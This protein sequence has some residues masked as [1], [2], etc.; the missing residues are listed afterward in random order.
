M[1]PPE[2][3]EESAELAR[4]LG[5]EPVCGSPLIPVLNDTPAFDLFLNRLF[6]GEVKT[7]I[8]TSATG[9]GAALQ[10]AGRRKRKEEL[11][12]NLRELDII[13]IGPRTGMSL[14][15]YGI[16]FR[17]PPAFTS[18]GI[19]ELISRSSPAK[20]IFVLRSDSGSGTLESGIRALGFELH[21]VIVYSLVKELKGLDP[22]IEFTLKNDIDAFAFT[23]SLSATAFLEALVAG[24]W[25][26]S[27]IMS[28]PVIGAIGPPTRSTL[29]SW[30]L[31][32]DV[33]PRR[34]TFYD[35]LI[36]VRNAYVE[37][38]C[39]DGNGIDG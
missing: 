25:N 2:R 16:E 12:K 22:I 18:E 30:G 33:V 32:V 17:L 14:K 34:A 11:L 15:R 39:A 29:E 27:Q 36:S 8:F 31:T 10:L 20:E 24:G 23:S 7:L 35:L 38:Q 21:E 6:A 4:R 3:L 28:G 19:V 37:K 9:V 13:A 26:P 5:M 1:R